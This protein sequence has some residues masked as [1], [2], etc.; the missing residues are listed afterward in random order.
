MASCCHIYHCYGRG[1]HTAS[2]G[3]IQ[4]AQARQRGSITR[5]HGIMPPCLIWPVESWGNLLVEWRNSETTRRA[6]IGRPITP[7][8]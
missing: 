2:T 5:L 4:Q 3:C 8:T 7:V 1:L 6:G